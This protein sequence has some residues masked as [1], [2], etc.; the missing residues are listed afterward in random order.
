ME[1]GY[2]KLWR[3]I[4]ESDLW[5]VNR[6]YTPLER[7]IDLVLSAN[8]RDNKW[9]GILIKRGMFATSQREL[10]KRWKLSLGGINFFL[11]A[12][13]TEHRIEL[14]TSGGFTLITIL[15]YN[16]FN[17]LNERPTEQRLN[18]NRT[19]TETTNKDNEVNKDNKEYIHEHLKITETEYNQLKE[20]FSLKDVKL[21]CAKANDWL[22]NSN[23][24]YKDFP[25]FMRNWLRKA[26]SVKDPP[27]KD[28]FF[29]KYAAELAQKKGI[30]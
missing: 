29:S 8:G 6:Q 20:K 5:P 19:A 28:D 11:N 23:K 25:A 10:S 2:I 17:P 1:T 4:R 12:L 21:E 26:P 24:R 22:A 3:K 27:K 13:K 30:R 9:H 18:T 14:K 16:D 15:K 7:W